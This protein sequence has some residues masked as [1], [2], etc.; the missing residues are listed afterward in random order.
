MAKE[1]ISFP[2]MVTDLGGFDLLASAALKANGQKENKDIF[3]AR[4]IKEIPVFSAQEIAAIGGFSEIESFA[5]STQTQA[6]YVQI[7]ER[8]PHSYLPDPCPQGGTGE[9]DRANNSVVQ[10]LY[11]IALEQQGLS[12]RPDDMVFVK[13][14][15]RD[16]SY[17]T[18]FGWIQSKAGSGQQFFKDNQ[19]CAKASAG[20]N[21]KKIKPLV[22]AESMLKITSPNPDGTVFVF[23]DGVSVEPTSREAITAFTN[24]LTQVLKAEDIPKLFISSGYPPR[25]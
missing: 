24:M 22:S 7:V 12:L 17:D 6:F 16:F 23:A 8:S 4:V 11:T 10:S 25:S 2:D 5:R 9:A 15:K 20:F 21:K 19:S 1:I 14:N 18:D 3:K 13:L